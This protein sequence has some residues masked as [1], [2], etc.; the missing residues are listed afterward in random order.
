MS[1]ESSVTNDQKCIF[2]HVLIWDHWKV[3]FPMVSYEITGR[4][5]IL[6]V[7]SWDAICSFEHICVVD[8]GRKWLIDASFSGWI[9]S[10]KVHSGKAKGGLWSTNWELNQSLKYDDM[11]SVLS[12]DRDSVMLVVRFMYTEMY[13]QLNSQQPFRSKYCRHTWRK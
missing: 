13:T 7:I 12:T 5:Y 11:I 9:T 8:E 4:I 2:M 3:H 10:V 1:N 6:P